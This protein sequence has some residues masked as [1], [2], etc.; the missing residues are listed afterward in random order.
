MQQTERKGS[1]NEIIEL[2]ELIDR[3]N[4][5]LLSMEPDMEHVE[6]L[7]HQLVAN[8]KKSNSDGIIDNGKIDIQIGNLHFAMSFQISASDDYKKE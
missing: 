8:V 7:L 1:L 5:E 4:I 6:E 3:L 2:F